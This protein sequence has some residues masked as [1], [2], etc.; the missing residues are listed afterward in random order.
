MKS[1]S[2]LP[3][4]QFFS[5]IG[6]N[7][8]VPPPRSTQKL[9]LLVTSR[10]QRAG[11]NTLL[12]LPEIQS[13]NTCPITGESEALVFHYIQRR[14]FISGRGTNMSFSCGCE[15]AIMYNTIIRAYKNDILFRTASPRIYPHLPRAPPLTL[16]AQ[17]SSWLE[18]QPAG[19]R[20][21]ENWALKVISSLL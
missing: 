18:L 16:Q 14:A 3:I 11:V 15:A 17:S 8:K 4:A 6:L 20:Q 12:S 13:S 7:C 1:G 19:D 9:T 21:P 10:T 2:C 5:F